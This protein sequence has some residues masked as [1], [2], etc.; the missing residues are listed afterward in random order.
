[1][2]GIN[3]DADSNELQVFVS[4]TLVAVMS[5]VNDVRD[6]AAIAS[7][8]GTGRYVFKAP[9]EIEFDIAVSARRTA[10]GGGKL[11]LEVFSVGVNAGGEKSAESSTVSRIKFSIPRIF[12]ENGRNE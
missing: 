11:K 7:A 5:A 9:N 10:Q 8:K 6:T 1:M 4:E 2:S 12:L 3:K